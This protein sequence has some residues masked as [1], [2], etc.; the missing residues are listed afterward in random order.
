MRTYVDRITQEWEFWNCAEKE[1][2]TTVQILVAYVGQ[3][4]VLIIKVSKSFTRSFV[5]EDYHRGHA[6]ANQPYSTPPEVFDIY[7]IAT[8][9]LRT[10]F[11]IMEN[12]S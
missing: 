6:T 2:W 4:A 8:I 1:K 3:D 5:A 7:L 9:N 10:S 12:R 11:P